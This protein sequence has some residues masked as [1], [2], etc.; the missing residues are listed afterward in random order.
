[1]ASANVKKPPKGSSLP[2]QVVNNVVGK[3]EIGASKISAT[4]RPSVKVGKSK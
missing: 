1:M 3:A 4:A 2:T